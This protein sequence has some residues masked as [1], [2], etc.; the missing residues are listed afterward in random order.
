M[1]DKLLFGVDLGTQTTKAALYRTDGHCIAAAEVDVPL[2]HPAP[3]VV[4]QDASDFYA[5]AAATV[6]RCLAESD[7]DPRQVA[8]IAFAGQMAGIGSVDE[9][10]RPAAPFDS[11]LDTRCRPYIAALEAKHG[12]RITALTGC[13]PTCNHGPKILWLAHERPA[14]Y[15]RVA[16]FVTPSAYVAGALAGLRGDDAFMDYTYLHFTALAD[17]QAGAWSPELVAV[18][19]VD[20]RRLPRIVAPWERIG[21]VDEA[22]AADFGL[23]PG[24]PIAAGL[25]DTA[26]GAL[27]AGC[28]QPG[29]LLDTAG[30]AAVLAGCTDRF[31]ADTEQRALLTMRSAVPGLWHPLAYIAGGGL[32][33]RWCRDRFWPQV[34]GDEGYAA[35]L[36]AA[37]AVSLG[38][39]ELY[40]SPHLGGR[41][42][43]AAPDMRGAWLGFSWGHD[44]GH[45]ARA[46]LEGV[47][48]EYAWYLSILRTL[49]PDQQW[50]EA[51]VIG[52]GA[53]ARLW[54][55]IKAAVLGLPWRPLRRADFATWGAALVAG[56]AVGLIDDLPAAAA[57]AA[58]PGKAVA[59]S[60]EQTAAYAPH[61]AR[62]V[63]WQTLLVEEFES[64][65]AT[66][67][68]G[69]PS[70][71]S[72]DYA[73]ETS[74]T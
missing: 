4:E 47:A 62:Y 61:A 51:Y 27:G 43:P 73:S 24:T 8:G 22:A 17:A 42:C 64:E 65:S 10:F 26:A 21:S 66:K 63:R 33:L 58:R 31:V 29:M 20:H 53:R 39:E 7:A 74:E 52:G 56:R 28:V 37:E 59:P 60:P 25:G 50:R 40:F 71:L 12:P 38:A 11:W 13:S 5:T 57:A 18:L 23:A 54:N 55:E 49:A 30:T 1:A 48:Y 70:A 44:R 2:R 15:A 9:R 45:F 6:R 16:K 36:T 67:S 46:I 69:A 34:P 32:A 35:L 41:V 3:G 19:G 68:T 14:D 72:A